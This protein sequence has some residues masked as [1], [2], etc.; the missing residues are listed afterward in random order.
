MFCR[1]SARKSSICFADA[2]LSSDGYRKVLKNNLVDIGGSDWI[3][4]EDS[5]PVHRS[6]VNITWFKSQNI[7]VLP[8]PSLSS[9][10]N[11]IA[12][13]WGLLVRKVDSEG[14]HFRTKEQLKT[15]I[16]KSWEKIT[17]DQLRNLVNSMPERIFEVIKLNGAKTR[18]QLLCLLHLF[19]FF[20]YFCTTKNYENT[21]VDEKKRDRNVLFL[22]ILK[23]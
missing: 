18:Y 6:K 22:L 1:C 20:V 17:I 11:R 4:Q 10:L 9:D 23:N 8:W 5:A 19:V 14:M 3:F 2:W 12:N 7:N 21:K 13:E 16:L 15:A